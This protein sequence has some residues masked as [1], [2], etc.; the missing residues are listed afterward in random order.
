MKD[1]II[2]SLAT[3]H[4]IAQ[5]DPAAAIALERA[6]AGFDMDLAITDPS[7]AV[8]DARNNLRSLPRACQWC[9]AP[10]EV[11]GPDGTRYRFAA[12][13]D[14]YCRAATRHRIAALIHSL[15]S[16]VLEHARTSRYLSEVKHDE[17]NAEEIYGRAGM[18]LDRAG[19][20]NDVGNKDKLDQL[21]ARVRWLARAEATFREEVLNRLAR[22]AALFG[23]PQTS[24]SVSDE[25]DK[26]EGL[27]RGR[28]L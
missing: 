16:E 18:A 8:E 27:I 26:I 15:R 21:A 3:L 13:T 24:T 14:E 20:P 7:A 25:F 10:L 23:E 4:E 11:A 9:A 28:L 22:L 2:I 12:H 6:G 5:R 17:R 19:V 1:H